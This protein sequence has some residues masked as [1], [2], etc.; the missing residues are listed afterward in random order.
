MQPGRAPTSGL[1]VPPLLLARWVGWVAPVRPIHGVWFV[2]ARP[3]V[4]LGAHVCAVSWATWLLFTSVPVWCV[5]SR[6]RCP[7]PLGSCSPA[8][9]LR[10]LSCVSGVLSHLAPVHLCA[11]SVQC[12][13]CAVSWATW[14][15]STSVLARCV[16]L[17]VRCPE[18][19]G[20]CSPVCPLVVLH[21]VCGVLSHFA[22]VHRCGGSVFC[23]VCAVSWATWLLFTS[24]PA[25]WVVLRVRC[26]GQLGSCSPVC[27]LVALHRVSGV[28]GHLAPVHRGVGSV[29]CVMCAVSWATWLLFTCVPVRWVL[30]RVRCPGP[31]GSCSP[32]CRLGALCRV[33]GVLG[34][35]APVHRCPR[36]MRCLACA[37]SWA[38]WLLFTCVPARCVVSRGGVASAVSWAAWL[39]FTGV[40]A[41]CVVLRV[42]CFGPLGSCSPV[43]L[44]GALR[45]VC[46]VSWATWLL[47]TGVPTRCVVSCTRFCLPLGSCSP[48]CSLGALRCMCAVSLATWLLF[49]GVA[50]RCAVLRARCPGQLGSCSPVC[51]LGALR[52]VCGVLGH[53]APVHRCACS[54]LRVLFAVSW[55]T[56][57]LFTGVPARCYVLCVRCPGPLGSCSPVYPLGALCCVCGVLGHLGPV[58]R[59]DRSVLCVA[60]A[61]SWAIWHLFTGVPAG[62]AVLHPRCPGPLGS[63]FF[64]AWGLP[65]GKH[66]SKRPK[67]GQGRSWRAEVQSKKRYM[68]QI[69]YEPVLVSTWAL[70]RD[71]WVQCTAL[72]RTRVQI[73]T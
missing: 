66:Y 7:G 71:I 52:C 18:P 30:S 67:H 3:W 21:R 20:S 47:F 38:T 33:C 16:V 34:H 70:T 23:V 57:L 29:C 35:L 50:A 58:H 64:D 9:P 65:P 54:M 51:P 36:S 63:C 60:C 59:C 8:C 4:A 13:V 22:P 32:V 45:C 26:P 37:V 55:A 68:Q 48:V 43:C 56:W 73:V 25:R 10:A 41:R 12:V 69:V 72:F 15:L 49:T 2:V 14:L 6:V 39:L 24:V 61:L 42:R 19:L 1:G 17:R 44:L 11:G 28:L 62:C 31:L 53:L 46:A 40:L 27:P 5:V